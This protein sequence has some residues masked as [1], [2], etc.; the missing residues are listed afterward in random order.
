MN[1]CVE[2]FF[3]KLVDVAGIF[4]RPLKLQNKTLLG[5][6]IFNSPSGKIQSFMFFAFMS[7]NA[8]LIV[9]EACPPTFLLMKITPARYIEIPKVP[10]YKNSRFPATVIF[11]IVGHNSENVKNKIVIFAINRELILIWLSILQRLTYC[12]LLT[13]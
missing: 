3:L 5:G 10:A 1:S 9:F 4:C 7:F 8:E 11:L 2:C 12:L 6:T 13:Q